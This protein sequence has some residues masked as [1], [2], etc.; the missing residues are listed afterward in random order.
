MSRKRIAIAGTNFAGYTAALELKELVGDNH[1]IV[2]VANTHKFLFF[3]SLIW[4]PFGLRD[5]KDITFDVRPIYST[6][7]I[8]FIEDEI[9]RFDPPNNQILTKTKGAVPY[10][11]LIIGTGPKVDYDYIPGVR[12]HSHS[13]VGLGPAQRT[14]EAWNR[15]LIHPGP[16]VVASAQGAACFGAAYEFLFNIRYQIAKHDLADKAPITYVTAEPF[17]AHFGIGGFGNAQKMCEWMFRHYSIDSRMNA[18]IE[19]VEA[20]GVLLKSGERLPSAF[21]M[22]MPRFLG[23]DAVRNTPG[24]ANDKGFIEVDDTYQHPAFKNV[25]AAG[26]AVH[27]V[28]PGPTQVPCGVP[29]TGWPTEQ[30]AKTAV[31]NIVASINGAPLVAQKFDDMAAYCIMDAGN[32]GMIIAGDHMLSPR[33]HEFI[34]PGPEAHWA[35]LAFEKYFLWTRR[36]AH[37]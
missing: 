24:L 13:I 15:F 22:V 8:E 36:H 3:P 7:G 19:R 34:I 33:E 37:V 9:E 35:K 5:E 17:A 12:E 21:T 6:H 28:P 4:Y 27:V 14:R 32:M 23:V 16:V 2:V 10:D 29:K 31:K 20:D 30:M 25:F 1:D 18:E 11:Y 26:V